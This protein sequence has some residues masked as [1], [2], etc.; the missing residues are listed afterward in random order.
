MIR[1]FG[2]PAILT[3]AVLG[4]CVGMGQAVAQ[5]PNSPAAGAS[6]ARGGGAAVCPAPGAAVSE[7]YRWYPALDLARI[8]FHTSA[9]SWGPRTPITAPAPPVTRRTVHVN[10]AAQLAAD[11][12]VPGSIIIVDAAFIGPTIIAGD[13]ADIDIVVPPGRRVSQLTIGRYTP[14]SVTRI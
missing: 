12:R 7:P 13:V 3:A 11:A 2:L 4:M 8:P 6:G 1:D 10:S 14:A 5:A 9:G